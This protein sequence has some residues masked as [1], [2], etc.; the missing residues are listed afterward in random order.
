MAERAKRQRNDLH[1]HYTSSGGPLLN[2]VVFE[3]GGGPVNFSHVN[4]G[5]SVYRRGSTSRLTPHTQQTPQTSTNNVYAICVRRILASTKGG[6]KGAKISCS[7]DHAH[8]W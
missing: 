1:G 2:G 4:P 8:G 6:L 7:R 5:K 3:T